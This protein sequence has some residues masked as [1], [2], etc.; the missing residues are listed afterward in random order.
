MQSP[1]VS[2][3]IPSC[4][5]PEEAMSFLVFLD[6]LTSAIWSAY[7]DKISPHLSRAQYLARLAVPAIIHDDSDIVQP[8]E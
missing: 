1:D 8:A 2:V 6:Q 4:W 3:P 5:T 7:G